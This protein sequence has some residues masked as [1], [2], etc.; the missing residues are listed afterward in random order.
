MDSLWFDQ[1]TISDI[2]TTV[3]DNRFET[4]GTSNLTSVIELSPSPV[5]VLRVE[6][7]YSLR[8]R[9]EL[10]TAETNPRKKFGFP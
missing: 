9:L 8:N 10:S 5:M 7:V 6:L 3:R 2:F 1:S 4:T